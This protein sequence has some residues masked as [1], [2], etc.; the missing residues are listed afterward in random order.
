MPQVMRVDGFTFH[1]YPNDHPPP[2]VHVCR[3]GA[4]GVV[5]LGSA[6]E[7]ASLRENVDMK[8][9]DARRAVW[10]VAGAWELLLVRW[11]KLHAQP[12]A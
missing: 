1:L 12:D 2:H 9:I 6:H 7:P 5:L 10:L 3:S 11:R 4:W 8:L